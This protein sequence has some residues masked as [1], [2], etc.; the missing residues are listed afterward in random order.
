MSNKTT[1]HNTPWNYPEERAFRLLS[2][3]SLRTGTTAEE[4][5]RIQEE[6][7]VIK[8]K[9][10]ARGIMICFRIKEWMRDMRLGACEVVGHLGNLQITY[11][12][13]LSQIHPI[14]Y[15]LAYERKWNP[16]RETKGAELFLEIPWNTVPSVI[17]LLQEHFED[18]LKQLD[19]ESDGRMGFEMGTDI[20]LDIRP[21]SVP[22]LRLTDA[23]KIPLDHAPTWERIAQAKLPWVDQVTDL[24]RLR[25]SLKAHPPSSIIDLCSQL[26]NAN[27][28]RHIPEVESG[29]FDCDWLQEFTE[30]TWMSLAH[31]ELWFRRVS[32][33]SFSDWEELMAQ[34]LD[35]PSAERFVAHA[36][37]APLKY[38]G[39]VEALR[40]YQCAYLGEV[41]AWL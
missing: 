14:Q 30:N 8:L 3:L 2:R 23:S 40:V 37:R 18:D 38:V 16:L 39:L 9:G 31:A 33:S 22:S 24:V 26:E 17:S 29:Q 11:A 35:L 36:R 10:V 21:S 13:G 4:R 27:G 34:G 32:K 1:P 12:L 6:L 28:L 15:G 5:R 20:F 41:C 25:N 19:T 7:R